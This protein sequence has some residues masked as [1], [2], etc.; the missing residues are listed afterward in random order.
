MTTPP[1]RA[2]KLTP[3]WK[4]PFRVK[5]VPNPYQ[6]VY[7]DGSVWQTV[8]VNHTKP[9]K[10]TA[11]DLPLPTPAPEPPRPTL[12]YLPRSLQRPCS[13]PPPPQAATPTGGS[14]PP[15]TAS[16]PMP[17]AP[18]PPASK[19]PTQGS[20]S[21]HENSAPAPQPPKHPGSRIQPPT[22]APANQNSGSAIRPLRS[23]RLNPGLDQACCLK[24]P[25][26]DRAPQSQQSDTMARTYPLTLGFNQCLGA[27]ENPC[28]FSSV[29]LEDLRS[30]EREYLSTIEQLVTALPKTEDPASRMALRGHITPAG[31]QRLRHSMQ[32]ALWWLLPSDGEFRRASRSLHYYLARQ[33]RRVVLRGGNVTRP[34]YESRVN[35]VID[36]APPASCRP[37]SEASSAPTPALSMPPSGD[38]PQ[39]PRRQKS[40]RRR[41][42]KAARPANQLPA[43]RQADVTTPAE[44]TANSNPAH[45]RATRLRSATNDRPEMRSTPVEH[46]RS[47]ISSPLTQLPIPTT[48]Q[49]S[50]PTSRRDHSEIWG[51]YKPAQT[52]PRQDLT[53][54]HS[55]DNISGLGL[56][57]PGFQQPFTKPFSGLP[58]RRLMTSPNRETGEA[59]KERPG[60]VYPLLP[61]ATRPDTR[62]TIDAALPESAALDRRSRPPTVL[63]I[64]EAALQENRQPSLTRRQPRKRRRNRSTGLYRPSKRSPLQGSW[65]E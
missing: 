27:K 39:P 4:G 38:A 24:G 1:E 22:S 62:L 2:N 51:L 25:P 21:A 54:T 50:E 58:S 55:R 11:P 65:C 29:Y 15:P 37:I 48:N 36:P 47:F 64:G 5:R 49:N 53:A 13:R 41:R 7:E 59:A 61:R 28:A 63:D 14:P 35:W 32:A 52:V 31:H 18:P 42:R 10:L 26:G 23:V 44:R 46:P 34:F 43:S 6:V 9:A 60:I 20:A 45:W 56:S 57:S 40:R 3:R 30:G 8:H 12:G 19:R 33:G 16:V 17:P